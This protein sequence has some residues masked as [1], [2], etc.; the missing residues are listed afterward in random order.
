MIPSIYQFKKNNLQRTNISPGGSSFS[1]EVQSVD[2]SNEEEF[3][4]IVCC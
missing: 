4:S 3:V 1:E 2:V